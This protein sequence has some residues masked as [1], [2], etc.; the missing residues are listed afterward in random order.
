[1]HIFCLVSISVKKL[2]L[3]C[4]TPLSTIFQ[5]YRGRQVYWL[6]KAEYNLTQHFKSYIV[7]DHFMK[8]SQEINITN[9][10]YVV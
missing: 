8:Q 9:Y 4:L 5:L 6:R 1:M 2:R 10:N 7:Q 3:W